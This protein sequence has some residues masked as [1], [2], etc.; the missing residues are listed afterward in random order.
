L[1]GL[2]TTIRQK[3]YFDEIY[4]FVTHQIIFRFVAAPIAWFD[5]NVVDGGVNLSGWIAQRASAS[6]TALQTGQVQTY[7]VWFVIGTVMALILFGWAGR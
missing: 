6:M 4:Q 5:R 3:F 2:Y 1:G 7:G